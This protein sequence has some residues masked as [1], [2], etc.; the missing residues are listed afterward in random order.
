MH[1]DF[2]FTTVQVLWTLT[3]AALLVLLVVLLGRER[4]RRFPW[5]TTAMVVMAL[6]LLA[7][8]LLFGRIPR[9]LANEIFLALADLAAI[10]ALLVAIELAR[11]AFK[12]ATRLAWIIWTLVLLAVG[13]VVLV[14]WGPWPSF[15]TL[16]ALSELSVLRLMEM[17]AQRAELLAGVLV[18]QLSVLIVLFGRRFHAGWR[19]HTQRIVIGLSTASLAQLAVQIASREIATHTAIRS[20]AVYVRVT[21]MLNNLNYA[22]SVIFLAVLVWWIVCL[23]IDEPGAGTA[24]KGDQQRVTSGEETAKPESA[25]TNVE[26][27]G[28]EAKPESSSE[29][30]LLAPLLPIPCSLSATPC[31]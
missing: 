8:R 16:F 3:F 28:A 13:A 9:V 22:N 1:F 5:F 14:K 29:A 19:S 7:S 12:G 10:L 18:I 23:W 25:K 20:H 15:K 31:I 26:A 24:S 11:R 2:H 17:V 27:N 4:V 21:G 6:R 30:W